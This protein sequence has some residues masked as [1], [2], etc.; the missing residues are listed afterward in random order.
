MAIPTTRTKE[1]ALI[2]INKEA[3]SGCGLCVTVCK[4]FCLSIEDKTAVTRSDSL[5]G[6]MGCGH[7]MAVCLTGAIIV[8]GREISSQDLFEL[9]EK[10]AMT[11]FE[12]L[13]ALLQQ[14][15]SVREFKN[16]DV[17]PATVEKILTAARTS[18]MG[19]P[20]S[21]VNVLILSGREKTRAFA[22]D[23]SEYLKSIRYMSSDFF[24]ALMRPFW[25]KENNELFKGFIKPLFKAYIDETDKG[26][27]HINYDAPLLMYFYGSPYCDPADP[28]VAATYAMIAGE[29][30]GLG[31]CMLGGVHPFIQN[32]RKAKRFRERHGIKYK[33][34]EG[35]FVA[36]GYPS[37]KF[38]KGIKRTFAS[39]QMS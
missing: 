30:L 6:C 9:P 8:T 23:F 33:S 17:E 35:L 20:P 13:L 2:S 21:D 18:P 34:R 31:T 3:C 10:D 22:Q 29:S 26:N 32:G 39:V 7:C 14:R 24:I 36:F 16:R 37:V 12:S 4:S 25:G 11:G 28:V 27:N 15:R 19:L 1:N 38:S 5:F